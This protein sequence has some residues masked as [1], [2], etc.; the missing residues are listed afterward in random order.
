MAIRA[1][2]AGLARAAPALA[3]RVVIGVVNVASSSRG[4]GTRFIGVRRKHSV[5]PGLA[6]TSLRRIEEAWAAR[7]SGWRRGAFVATATPRRHGTRR[8]AGQIGP[9][10]PGGGFERDGEKRLGALEDRAFSAARLSVAPMMDL[11]E[12]PE[13]LDFEGVG[14]FRPIV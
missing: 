2:F 3:R 9:N 12:A 5:R 8:R 7:G 1:V 14:A 13:A 11:R 4:G 6:P 10:P